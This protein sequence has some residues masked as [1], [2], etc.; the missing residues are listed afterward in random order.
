MKLTSLL[1]CSSNTTTFVSD[2]DAL[3][4]SNINASSTSIGSS[5]KAA[6]AAKMAKSLKNVS[7]PEPYT[8]LA[9]DALFTRYA[10]EDDPSVIGPEG[11]EKMCGAAEI[12]LEGALPLILAW[13]F[14]ASEMAKLSKSEWDKGTSQLQ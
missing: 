9:A 12:S 14:G 7:D 3:R 10:D 8:A 4:S 13:Q 2:D 11:L 1:C 6:K 5:T